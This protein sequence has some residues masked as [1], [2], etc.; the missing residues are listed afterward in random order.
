MVDSREPVKT[1]CW[2]K[3]AS[4]PESV[5]R[6]APLV[7]RGFTRGFTPS[8]IKLRVEQ[9]TSATRVG[10]WDQSDHRNPGAWDKEATPRHGSFT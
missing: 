4:P 3:E 7:P 10:R 8:G 5:P 2:G 6:V 1:K 9:G